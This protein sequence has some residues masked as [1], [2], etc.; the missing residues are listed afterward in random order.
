M[1]ATDKDVLIEAIADCAKEDGWANLAEVG[2][3]LR[4]KGIKYGKLS[5]FILNFSEI[6]QTKVDEIRQPPVVYAR[7]LT[8][9]SK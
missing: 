6:V 4:E 7:L 1:E 3:V 5:K 2:V 9:E 8:D